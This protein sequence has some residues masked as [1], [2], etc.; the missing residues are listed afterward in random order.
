MINACGSAY[1]SVGRVLVV[2]FFGLLL[3]LV[4]VTVMACCVFVIT[5]YTVR[6]CLPL[7]QWCVTWE[8]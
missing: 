5:A 8:I 4:L 7:T 6:I 2:I 1:G 3:P